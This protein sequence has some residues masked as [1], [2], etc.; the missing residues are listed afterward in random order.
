MLTSALELPRILLQANLHK[1]CDGVDS[2]T[3]RGKLFGTGVLRIVIACK[4][5]V[6]GIGFPK[7]TATKRTKRP[8]WGHN[9]LGNAIKDARW[10]LFPECSIPSRSPIGASVLPISNAGRRYFHQ[11]TQSG[12]Q[13]QGGERGGRVTRLRSNL[14]GAS[15]AKSTDGR[16]SRL[17]EIYDIA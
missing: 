2:D 15:E 1:F 5:N 3:L 13:D 9:L 7:S 11:L 16:S 14:N 17:Q 6:L 8:N 12:V 4:D 10:M